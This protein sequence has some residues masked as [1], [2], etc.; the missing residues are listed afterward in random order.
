MQVTGLKMENRWPLS[1][2]A[3][4]LNVFTQVKMEQRN[5]DVIVS[6]LN[7][8]WCRRCLTLKSG[9]DKY[10]TR[11][12][13]CILEERS[14]IHVRMWRNVAGQRRANRQKREERIKKTEK[15]LGKGW[16]EHR[17]SLLATFLRLVAV[18]LWLTSSHPCSLHLS[19]PAALTSAQFTAA[20]KL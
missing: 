7:Y 6:V 4:R 1:F 11:D 13:V 10:A 12:A 8:L 20:G 14:Q 3:A 9:L 5:K 16:K 18:G 19:W 2:P 15:E 17:C